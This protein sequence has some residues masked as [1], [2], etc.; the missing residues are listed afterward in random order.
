[1]LLALLVL[2]V[3]RALQV[4]LRRLLLLL[5]LFCDWLFCCAAISLPAGD[6]RTVRRVQ[7]GSDGKAARGGA[8]LA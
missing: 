4:L 1:M 8:H 5:L 6:D 7:G 3:L 2:L